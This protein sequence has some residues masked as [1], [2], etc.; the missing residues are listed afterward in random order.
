MVIKFLY[1]LNTKPN[2]DINTK[3]NTDI[4][5]KPNTDIDTKPNTDM[6]W[7]L[8]KRMALVVDEARQLGLCGSQAWA[9]SPWRPPAASRASG[10][11]RQM[12]LGLN[13]GLVFGISWRGALKIP[14]LPELPRASRIC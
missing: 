11:S 5:T 6:K 3:P 14:K 7:H 12:S 10:R 8:Q 9:P 1:V 2:T 13:S 4:D